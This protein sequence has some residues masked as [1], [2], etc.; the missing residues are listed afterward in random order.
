MNS[1]LMIL[2]AA[3]AWTQ[4]D[5]TQRPS[6]FWA[7]EFA[8]PHRLLREAGVE[9]TLATPGGMPAVVDKLSLSAQANNGN[10]S[11]VAELSAYLDSVAHELSRPRRLEELDLT[12]FDAVLV[13]GGHGPMQDLAVSP[14]AGRLLAAA[15]DDPRMIVASI[16]HG[17]A[18]FLAA[19]DESRW[20]FRGRRLTSFSNV[21]ETQVGLAVNA[22]WL[23]ED[24]L[25]AAGA[26]F[27]AGAPWSS[28]V[29][30][31]GRLIT[32]QNPQSAEAVVKA[33]L[34]ALAA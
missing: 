27:E 30:V 19:G 17:Q 1:V 13:P 29:V 9:V 16:C 28:T 12:G 18:A 5:G 34:S 8:T 22:P 7:E 33:L 31:D 10:E 25:R 11:R 21:E 3:T 24:R 26:R 15:M 6:G 32:G 20:A 4:L 2:T 23:L 14:A